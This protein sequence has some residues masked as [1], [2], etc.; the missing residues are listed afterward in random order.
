[1]PH[2]SPVSHTTSVVPADK[3]DT[4]HSYIKS[5]WAGNNSYVLLSRVGPYKL[6]YKDFQI[7][8][9]KELESEVINAYLSLKVRDHNLTSPG[10]AFHMD[11]FAM[12]DM[13]KKKYRRL[14]AVYPSKKKS[15]L[16]D[17]MGE[18]NIKKKRCLETT[19]YFCTTVRCSV[20]VKLCILEKTLVCRALMTE[21]GI[22]ASQWVCES[23]PHPLQ[24]DVTSCGVFALKFAEHILQNTAVD[25]S[26]RPQDVTQYRMEI[27]LFLLRQ[28]DDLSD[29]CHFCG[30]AEIFEDAKDDDEAKD[31]DDDSEDDA[32]DADGDIQW[33]S[34][35]YC[36]RWF[37][38][39][40]VGNPSTED[41]YKCA[42]CIK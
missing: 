29:L 27:A 21:N 6:F 15:I 12:T 34:C 19:R 7:G 2:S 13:W 4:V 10:K 40:C 35:D 23:L 17:S 9:G 14:K 30:E 20:I 33:I 24:R 28:S 39:K 11:T 22:S 38:M 25:F 41:E 31:T 1:M 16:L 26:N 5:A 42:S 36:G 3:T 8:P 32:K 37:H 18:S